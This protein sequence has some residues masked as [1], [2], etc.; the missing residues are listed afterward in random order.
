MFLGASY[1]DVYI[2]A[3]K[4]ERWA[5]GKKGLTIQNVI[6][7]AG[8]LGVPLRRKVRPDLDDDDGI[9]NV[10][11]PKSR[12]SFSGHFVVLYNGMIVDPAGPFVLPHDEWFRQHDGRP[13][14]LLETA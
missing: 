4:T 2:A 7:M 13:G 8:R 6:E 5:R 14:H 10:S 3:A 9:L 12:D 11:W 1:E